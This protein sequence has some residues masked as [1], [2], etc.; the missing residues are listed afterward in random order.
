MQPQHE[1]A[2]FPQ[3]YICTPTENGKLGLTPAS[4]PSAVTQVT[5]PPKAAAAF[6][7][8]IVRKSWQKSVW[9]LNIY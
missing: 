9:G 5:L 3:P 6:P 7:S 1:S 4:Y 2:S 8:E